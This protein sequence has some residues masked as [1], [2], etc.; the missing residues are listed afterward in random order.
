MNWPLRDKACIVGVGET[1]Y[2]KW[3]GI[4]RSEFSLA[5]EAIVKAVADAGLSVDDVDGF[6]AYSHERDDPVAVAQALGVKEVRYSS[7]YPGGGNA[8]CG[9]VH[10]AAMAV[11]TQTADVVVCYRSRCQGQYGRASTGVAAGIGSDNTVGGINQFTVPFGLIAPAALYAFEARRH[12]HEYG[13][14][15]RQF[16]AISVACYK[17]AQRNPR[18]VMYGRPITIEDHQASRM[19]AD[20]YRLYDCCQ[21]SDGACAVVVTREDRAESLRKQPVYITAT[22]LGNGAMDGLDRTHWPGNR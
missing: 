19:I 4:H 17:H 22:A 10:N 12:M 13:T 18:A 15:S 11:Y 6:V 20:P 21:E 2:T 1:E 9:I 7:L 8:A 3:G 5:C 14:T 16:G